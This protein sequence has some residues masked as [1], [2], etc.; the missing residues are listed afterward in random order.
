MINRNAVKSLR[1]MLATARATELPRSR[2][3][4][5][6]VTE[7]GSA[8]E[9]LHAFRRRL[10]QQC[11]IEHFAQR[12]HR[13][14]SQ[15]IAHFLRNILDVGLVCLGK[16]DVLDACVMLAEHFFLEPS[17]RKCATSQSYLARHRHIATN[18]T[19]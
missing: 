1:S 3:H 19:I 14:K 18:C 13:M 10:L 17:N 8:F 11:D 16:D 9:R 15:C 7:S 12:F 5:A 6:T 2:V 4:T